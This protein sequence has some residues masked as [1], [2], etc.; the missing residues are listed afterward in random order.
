MFF[1]SLKGI[2]DYPSKKYDQLAAV[3]PVIEIHTTLTVAF[4]GMLTISF[5]PLD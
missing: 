2:F 4:A 5:S 3:V 1:K